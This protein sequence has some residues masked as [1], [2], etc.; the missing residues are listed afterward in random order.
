MRNFNDRIKSFCI[1]TVITLFQFSCGHTPPDEFSDLKLT[2]CINP[3]PQICTREYRPVCGFE[4][5]GNHKTYSNACTAC[6]S[7]D[8]ISYCEGDCNKEK[9]LSK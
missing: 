2:Q 4:E 1:V 9:S 3:K 7:P 6:A 5:D 8:V